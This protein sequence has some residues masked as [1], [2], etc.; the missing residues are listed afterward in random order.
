MLAWGMRYVP[1]TRSEQSARIKKPSLI[2]V[3]ALLLGRCG[4]RAYLLF[5]HGRL[6][7]RDVVSW[8]Q[9]SREGGRPRTNYGSQMDVSWIIKSARGRC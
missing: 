2:T 9:S 3:V 6:A 4:S 8:S 5:P 7:K 1:R